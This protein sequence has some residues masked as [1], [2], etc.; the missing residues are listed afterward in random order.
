MFLTRFPC[1]PESV[2]ADSHRN[3]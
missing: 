1:A 3:S 2:I